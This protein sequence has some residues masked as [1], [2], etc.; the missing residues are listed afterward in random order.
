[1]NYLYVSGDEEIG[2]IKYCI[3]PDKHVYIGFLSIHPDFQKN[4]HGSKMLKKFLE[5]LPNLVKGVNFV[6]SLPVTIAS[7]KVHKRAGMV[8]LGFMPIMPKEQDMFPVYCKIYRDPLGQEPLKIPCGSYQIAK[9]ILES[10]EIKREIEF[11]IWSIGTVHYL[12]PADKVYFTEKTIG[13]EEQDPEL[14]LNCFTPGSKELANMI[15]SSQRA[16]K[17]IYMSALD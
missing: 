17:S 3:Y 11:D 16:E 1:M 15:I 13:Y 6:T 2:Y 7:E 14:I 8:P 5:D 9:K 4:G 12:D 10:L